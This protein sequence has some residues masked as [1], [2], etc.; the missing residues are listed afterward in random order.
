MEAWTE[1]VGVDPPWEEKRD[2][3]MLWRGKTT[4]IY[5]KEGVPWSEWNSRSYLRQIRLHRIFPVDYPAD[6]SQRINLVSHTARTSGQTPV[7][8]VPEPL[9]AVGSP[10]DTALSEL[11]A[12]LVDV[13]FVDEAIQCDSELCEEIGKEYKFGVRKDWAAGNQSVTLIIQFIGLLTAR[14]KY[15]LDLGESASQRLIR[16]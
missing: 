3:R 1:D 10:R 2:D 5:F 11:N 14:Y 13:A 16:E 12:D 6:I 8:D 4:G 7:Y 9:K 15:L